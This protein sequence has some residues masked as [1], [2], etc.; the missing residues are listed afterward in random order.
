MKTTNHLTAT[1]FYHDFLDWL[2]RLESF[3]AD[4]LVPPMSANEFYWLARSQFGDASRISEKLNSVP[5]DY[6]FD[7]RIFTVRN[8]KSNKG[9]VQTTTILPYDV[10]PLEK[11][12]SKYKENEKIWTVSRSTPWKYYKNASIL[13]GLKIC[14]IKDVKIIDNAWTHLLRSSC[15]RM[16][17]DLGAKESLIA[18]KMR[19][20]PRSVTQVYTKVDLQT[21]LDFEDEHLAVCPAKPVIDRSYEGYVIA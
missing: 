1:T 4:D 12:L 11:F 8:P 6:D 2:V 14:G 19:H 21:V 15:A 13:G 7:H 20:S 17:E 9:G 3:H 18:R 5:A 10:K 16:Y